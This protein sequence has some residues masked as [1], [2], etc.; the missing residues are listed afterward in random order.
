[1]CAEGCASIGGSSKR[2][3]VRPSF[4]STRSRIPSAPMSSTMNFMRAFTRDI[5]YFRSSL[6]TVVVAP[7]ISTA[8]SFGTKTP[9]S[10]AMRG[11]EA[12]PPPTWTA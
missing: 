8:S 11:T 4:A 6:H 12:R 9:M 1:M 5:R 7:R 2:S 10:R 3:S